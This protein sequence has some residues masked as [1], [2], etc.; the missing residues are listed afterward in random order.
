MV[1]DKACSLPQVRCPQGFTRVAGQ[2]FIDGCVL[3]GEGEARQSGLAGKCNM[4]CCHRPVRMERTLVVG[5]TSCLILV[6]SL[7]SIIE[8]R[9]VMLNNFHQMK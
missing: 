5:E 1:S 9:I 2:S 3:R 7:L 8:F 4:I 6:Y